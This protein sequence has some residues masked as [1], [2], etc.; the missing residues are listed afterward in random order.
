MEVKN[1]FFEQGALKWAMDSTLI[2]CEDTWLGNK[3]LEAQYP[4]IFNIGR[5]KNAFVMQVLS[6]NP[7][8]TEFRR[9]LTGDKWTSWLKL[10]ERLM[11]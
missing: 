9:N 3:P 5:H 4:F 7:L 1:D 10:V 2:F 11:G 6:A 8:N